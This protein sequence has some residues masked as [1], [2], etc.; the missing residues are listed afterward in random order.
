M[1]QI[2]CANVLSDLYAF[3]ITSVDNLLMI[4]G[5]PWEMSSQERD[6][7]LGLLR[8]GFKER[9]T[10]AGATIRGGDTKFN[11]W[12]MLGG[13]ATSI[14]KSPDIIRPSNAKIGDAILL[15]KP[16]GTHLAT[17]LHR[18]TTDA[19]K[20]ASVN[21]VITKSEIEI[22]YNMALNSMIHL[23][24]TAAHLMH[25]FEAHAATDI[26]GYG[27]IGH[28]ETLIKFQNDSVDFIIDK[29]P[30]IKNM[31]KVDTFLGGK[32]KLLEGRA[33]ETS[34]GLLVCLPLE[35]VEKFQNALMEKEN[36]ESWQIGHVVQGNRQV[37]LIDSQNLTIINVG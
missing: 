34:G 36:W 24:R 4:V 9:A 22:S 1:G 3:G 14:V 13:V 5:L 2:A 18:W 6:V 31:L 17:T 19:E 28:A 23:N 12:L 33:I 8:D 7:T 35:N 16:L 26:T 15:T 10:Q 20:L 21:A 25:L 29:L 37:K 11:A 30:I 27:L 32:F